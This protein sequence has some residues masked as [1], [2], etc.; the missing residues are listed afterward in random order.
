MGVGNLQ[1]ALDA[2]GEGNIPYAQLYFDS[3][4]LRHAAAWNVIS[5]LG[6]QSSTYLWKVLAAKAIMRQWRA[7][8]Q[9]LFRARGAPGREELGRGRAAPAGDDDRVRRP[10]GA[11]ARRAAGAS[12]SR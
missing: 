4:P 5:S 2:Y 1:H 12:S 10:R 8:P 7:D 11:E 3:S 6:D 9:R